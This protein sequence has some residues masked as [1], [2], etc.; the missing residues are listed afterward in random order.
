MARQHRRHEHHRIRL[1]RPRMGPHRT[2]NVRR[3]VSTHL[4]GRACG[5]GG[6]HPV[7]VKNKIVKAALAARTLSQTEALEQMLRDAMPGAHYR[8]AD[9]NNGN[10]SSITS[11]AE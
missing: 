4:V 3:P 5:R 7:N 6:D 1:P 2:R 8:F 11:G 9:D 10:W